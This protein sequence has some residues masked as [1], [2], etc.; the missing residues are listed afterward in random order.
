MKI[1]HLPLSLYKN[2]GNKIE[3]LSYM[4]PKIPRASFYIYMVIFNVPAFW[5]YFVENF[6]TVIG[7]FSSEM[8]EPILQKLGVFVQI[9]VK[10]STNLS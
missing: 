4:D 3:S 7:W 2:A 10:K 9:I 8:K 5:G 1:A 6:G